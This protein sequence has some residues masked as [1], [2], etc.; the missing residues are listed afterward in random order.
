MSIEIQT[1][2]REAFEALDDAGVSP[3]TGFM[4]VL[5]RL[6]SMPEDIP[7][8][9]IELSAH[10]APG[11]RY[12]VVDQHGRRVAGVRSV[13]VFEDNTGKPVFQVNL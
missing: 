7:T 11:G 4:Q 6:V 2:L 10:V 12:E 1:A 9:D 8:G 13:A 5:S 3:R